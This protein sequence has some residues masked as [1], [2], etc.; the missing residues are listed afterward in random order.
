MRLLLDTHAFLWFAGS[1]SRLGA[2]ALS[3]IQD[4]TNEVFL[5][6]A[7]AWE[8]SVKVSIGKL[9]LDRPVGRFFSEQL[10]ANQF[11]LL[12]VSLQH[13]VEVA[14]LPF[15]HRDP[16]DRMLIAQCQ[17]ES[18]TLVSADVLLDAYAIQ[19]VW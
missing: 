15:H 8:I 9:T 10:Q 19:R 18:L 7:S 13:A 3:L 2:Q 16:F 4:P 1:D 11:S 17:V 5:S 12:P 6:I 14:G